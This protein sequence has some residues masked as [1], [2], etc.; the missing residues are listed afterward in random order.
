VTPPATLAPRKRARTARPA[1]PI[2]AQAPPEASE[3]SLELAL[4]QAEQAV[5][6]LRGACRSAP[7]RYE[8]AVR[9]RLEALAHHLQ[10]VAEFV[11]GRAAPPR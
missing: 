9:Y 2:V 8:L 4:R 5:T 7:A 10:Q 11:A 3:P 1:V 6:Q